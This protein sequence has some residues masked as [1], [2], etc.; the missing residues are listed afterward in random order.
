MKKVKNLQLLLQYFKVLKI[1]RIK[2]EKKIALFY[3]HRRTL[4]VIKVL[5]SL[6]KNK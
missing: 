1:E 4:Q 2:I 6:K 3:F 5:H